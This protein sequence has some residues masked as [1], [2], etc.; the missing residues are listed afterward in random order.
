MVLGVKHRL[1]VLISCAVLCFPLRGAWGQTALF[2]S[3][4]EL[5]ITL[6]GN[7]GALMKDRGSN[8]QYHRFT[9]AYQLDSQKICR[10][11]KGA[12]TGAF[13]KNERE[14]YVSSAD[15]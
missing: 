13:Q 6:S 10:A 14:L 11:G 3:D 7:M 15:A 4:S 12:Y 9:L 1:I 8:P 2:A 5:E